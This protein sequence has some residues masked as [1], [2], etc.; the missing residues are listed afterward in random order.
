MAFVF[1]YAGTR[2]PLPQGAKVYGVE[3]G[4]DKQ[5][6]SGAFRCDVQLN[7]APG[8]VTAL[9]FPRGGPELEANFQPNT[10]A[11]YQV[12]AIPL[13]QDFGSP[14][15]A[16][17]ALRRCP[18]LK[19]ADGRMPA[20][21]VPGLRPD[22]AEPARAAGHTVRFRAMAKDG[23]EL[24]SSA[25]AL[26]EGKE[27]P[28]L[29]LARWVQPYARCGQMV[30][31]K[32]FVRRLEGSQIF[33]EIE[34]DAGKPVASAAAQVSGGQAVAQWLVPPDLCPPAKSKDEEGK[35]ARKLRFHALAPFENVLS[36]LL[37]IMPPP[38]PPPP[39]KPPPKK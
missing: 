1:V 34:D 37:P 15:E 5:P 22:S 11:Q 3:L 6:R 16:Y 14:A 7:G 20:V 27:G 23:E 36:S 21:F 31:L 32:V 25:I 26:H 13:A 12:I 28:R 35:P 24:V 30:T 18:V 29:A 39:P 4:S 10:N 19:F 33:F 17:K 38:M 2:Q 9:N 8:A